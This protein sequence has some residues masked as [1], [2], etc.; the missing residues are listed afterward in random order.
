MAS[1]LLAMRAAHG[2]HLTTNER[3][4]F[5]GGS[6]SGPSKGKG[7]DIGGKKER[8]LEGRLTA[9]HQRAKERTL[10]ASQERAKGRLT[11]A[12]ER[13]KERARKTT[14]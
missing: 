4:R 11:A 13:A 8:R 14:L 9:A 6:G 10:A 5:R 3:F 1:R 7:K 2:K 12:Q